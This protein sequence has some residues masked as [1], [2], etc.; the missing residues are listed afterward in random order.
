MLKRI[1]L[2]WLIANFVLA[3]LFALLTGG[4][5]LRLPVFEGMLAE[6]GLIVLPN[7]FFSILLLRYAWPM[8]AGNLRQA[9]GW[10]WD[11]WRPILTGAAA[12]VIYLLLS[13]SFAKLLGPG[14]PYSQPGQGGPFPG[15]LGLLALLLYLVFVIL[16]V[17][18]EE[19]MFRGLIQTQVSKR[20][21]VWIGVLLTIVL[22]GLRHLPADIFYAHVWNATPRMWLAR[23]VDLYLGAIL[24]S[25][26]RY[27]GRSTYASAIM[28]L[29]IFVSIFISGF[30]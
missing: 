2:A 26:A 17:S 21:G 10:Q 14:I 8:P 18:G 3:G 24:F 25:V 20:Y 22:F 16:T 12:F 30:F 29:L 15:L 1:F 5:Y 27:F 28:H 6:L 11:G 9:L 13:G 23:E 7:L 19:T 4:W